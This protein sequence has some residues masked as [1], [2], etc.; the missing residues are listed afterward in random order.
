MSE[1]TWQDGKPLTK[2]ENAE[3]RYLSVRHRDIRMLGAGALDALA[4]K[5][6]RQMRLQA[7]VAQHGIVCFKCGRPAE[8]WAKTGMHGQRPWAICLLCVRQKKG[9]A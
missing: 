4:E 9:A 7:F 1:A 8:E 2:A 6:E 5:H 3:L